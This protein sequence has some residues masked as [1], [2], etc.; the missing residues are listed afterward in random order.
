M[1]IGK[2]GEGIPYPIKNQVID[3]LMYQKNRKNTGKGSEI[4]I[5]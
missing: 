5:Q 2:F 3:K 4:Y 1:F